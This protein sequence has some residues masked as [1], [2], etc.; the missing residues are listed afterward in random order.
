[1]PFFAMESILGVGTSLPPWQE[2]D[3]YPWSSERITMTLGFLASTARRLGMGRAIAA[4]PM[5][6]N[7]RN[8]RLL[9]LWSLMGRVLSEIIA[10]H[11]GVLL[12]Q[13][14]HAGATVMVDARVCPRFTRDKTCTEDVG[15]EDSIYC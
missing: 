12:R 10:Y 4:V 14:Q 3:A 11:S 13:L 15:G 9:G 5:P 7:L 8:C 6:A 1:M 2:I